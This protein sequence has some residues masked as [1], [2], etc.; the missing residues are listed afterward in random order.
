MRSSVRVGCTCVLTSG[1]VAC[2]GVV[3]VLLQVVFPLL[4]QIP[5]Q[6]WQFFLQLVPVEPL[7]TIDMASVICLPP[8]SLVSLESVLRL[9]RLL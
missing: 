5:P 3:W 2:V 9:H 6:S 4:L 1:S 7:D 8:P